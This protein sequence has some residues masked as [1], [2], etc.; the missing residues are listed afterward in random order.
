MVELTWIHDDFSLLQDG[1]NGN[2]NG[3]FDRNLE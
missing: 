1:E 3:F 2:G